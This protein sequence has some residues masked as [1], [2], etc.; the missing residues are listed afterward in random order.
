VAWFD[1]TGQPWVNPSPNLR[2]LL[3]ATLYP[4]VGAIEWANISV[5]RGTDTPFEQ[6]GAPWIDGVTLAETLNTRR[7]PGVSFYPVSFTPRANRYSGELCRG[8]FIV[9]TDRHALRPV[10]LGVEIAAALRRQ[11]PAA[12][13]LARTAA[14]LGSRGDV[15]KLRDGIDPAE[16]A[17][18]WAAGEGRWRRLRS[19]YL[20]Y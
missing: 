19:K 15:E 2:N 17:A 6:I 16:V 8:V 5:G 11:H 18:S 1:Q 7:L 10:R 14:L 20:L 3:E 9:I 13:D 12:F 4:G